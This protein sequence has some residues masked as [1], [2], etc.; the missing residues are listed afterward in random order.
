MQELQ[1]LNSVNLRDG[2]WKAQHEALMLARTVISDHPEALLPCLHAFVA[3][4]APVIDS[5]RSIPARLAIQTLHELVEALG[6]ALDGELPH[7]LPLLVRRCGGDG[8]LAQEA[9][10]ALRHVLAGCVAP[11]ANAPPS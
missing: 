6:A 3:A 8:F 5:L 2:D 7:F 1:H 4:A 10:R 11:V 9:D